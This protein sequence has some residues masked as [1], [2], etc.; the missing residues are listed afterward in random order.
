MT[1][2]QRGVRLEAHFVNSLRA[3]TAESVSLILA[4]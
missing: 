3:A 2:I 4:I 1:F